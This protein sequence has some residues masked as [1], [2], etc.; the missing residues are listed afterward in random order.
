MCQLACPEKADPVCGSNDVT[1]NSKCDLDN[2]AR[3][4][5]EL[6]GLVVVNTGVCVEKTPEQL[7]AGASPSKA[8][9]KRKRGNG[10]RN[11]KS[12]SKNGKSSKKSKSSKKNGS[13]KRSQNK[14]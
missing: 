8:N 10:R 5:P 11:R 14:I 3:C 2:A 4:D 7:A 12:S 1:Y 13:S 9:K 6:K